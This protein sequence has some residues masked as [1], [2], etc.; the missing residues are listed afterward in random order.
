MAKTSDERCYI[1]YIDSKCAEIKLNQFYRCIDYAREN[2]LKAKIVSD[3]DSG[4]ELELIL[5]S[6]DSS[7]NMILYKALPINPIHSSFID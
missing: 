7:I 1:T 2:K 3:Y 5:F 6:D 4:E